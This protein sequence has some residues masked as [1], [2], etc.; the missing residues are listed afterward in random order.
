[1]IVYTPPGYESGTQRYPV[2][3]LYH[4][5]GE[6]ELTWTILGRAPEISIT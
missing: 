2:F 3:Y 1:M 6:D 4:G 5:G